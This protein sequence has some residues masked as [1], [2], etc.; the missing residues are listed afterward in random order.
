M[1][2][3]KIS[4]LEAALSFGLEIPEINKLIIGVNNTSQLEEII[5]V[6]RKPKS[7]KKDFSIN[8]QRLVNPTN[9]Q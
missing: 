6:S 9:W 1:F 7:I 2:L 3:N 5:E 4:P 8:D